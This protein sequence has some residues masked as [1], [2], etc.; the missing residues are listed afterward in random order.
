MSSAALNPVAAMLEWPET[1]PAGV[2]QGF[3]AL[4]ADELR[5]V[6]LVAEGAFG[7]RLWQGL[8]LHEIFR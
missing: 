3:H 6:R 2:S 5:R 4:T 1:L 8:V 7:L